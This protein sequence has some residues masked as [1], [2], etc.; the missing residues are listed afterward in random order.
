VVLTPERVL[1]PQEARSALAAEWASR[2][3]TTDEEITQFYRD[4]ACLVD[5]LAAFHTD[6]ERQGWT[7]AV[8]YLALNQPVLRVLDIGCGA[9]HDLLA[10][11]E[12][13]EQFDLY[14]VE[15]NHRLRAALAEQLP[16]ATLLEDVFRAPIEAVD[17][18]VCIDV[19]EHLPDPETFLL[20]VARRARIGTWLIEATATHDCGTPLHLAR[21]RGWKAGRALEMAGWERIQT[22]GRFNVWRRMR[23][24]VLPRATVMLC[25]NG[26]ISIPT[27][28]SILTMK[29]ALH[30]QAWRVYI[31][32]EAGIHRSRNIAASSWWRD[33]ADDVFVMVD[34]DITFSPQDIER[35][36]DRCRNGYPVICGAYAKRD[37]SGLALRGKWGELYFGE[38]QQPVEIE[39]VAT[40]FLA[41]HRSVL[42]TLIPTLPL[43]HAMTSFSFW[44]LFD[45]ETLQN[46][47]GDWEHLS[48]DYYF[49]KIARQH[50]YAS[51]VDPSIILGHLGTVEINVRN[52]TGIHDALKGV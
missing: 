41:V 52:M 45:F 51:Y 31:G 49:S 23:D 39:S 4:S 44:P 10:L 47:Q 50:G 9:G 6:P 48:E 5:D 37:G 19:L 18:L 28:R 1:T 30:D 27:V 42:D 11:R 20:N 12:A 2:V 36:A 46:E 33:T 8:V 14:G 26:S 32:G 25:A 38:G 17:M 16:G 7:R 15:P 35:L 21:N 29:E 43:C 34:S 3:P 40:G 13:S 22:Q 24:A